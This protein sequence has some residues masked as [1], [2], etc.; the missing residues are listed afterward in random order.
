MIKR[1]SFFDFA[2]MASGA[3]SAFGGMRHEI[4]TLVQSQVEKILAKRGLVSREDFEAQERITSLGARIAALRSTRKPLIKS[5]KIKSKS[6]KKVRFFYLAKLRNHHDSRVKHILL[7]YYHRQPLNIVLH[8]DLNIA[9]FTR[10]GRCLSRCLFG[11]AKG[12]FALC[13]TAVYQSLRFIT[14]SIWC[15]VL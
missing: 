12:T 11:F 13:L 4:E 15:H 7:C 3:A 14:Q 1:P 8:C 9:I 10:V 2:S 5:P 6:G